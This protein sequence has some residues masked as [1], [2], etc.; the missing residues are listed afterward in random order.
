MLRPIN[1]HGLPLK[2]FFFNNITFYLIF[3]LGGWVGWGR[4][5][6]FLSLSFFFNILTTVS[7]PSYPLSSPSPHIHSSSISI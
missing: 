4:C 7:P 5:F 1:T 3:I 6:F 2:E